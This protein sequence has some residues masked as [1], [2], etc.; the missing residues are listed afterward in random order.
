MFAR[1]KKLM[2]ILNLIYITKAKNF[3]SRIEKFPSQTLHTPEK[4]SHIE[5]RIIEAAQHEEREI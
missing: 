4:H 5:G 2:W 1:H 3:A